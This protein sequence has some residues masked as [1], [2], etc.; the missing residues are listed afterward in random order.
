MAND[1]SPEPAKR[2]VFSVSGCITITVVILVI[3]AIA[4]PGLM[5]MR[6]SSGE[7]SAS[8]S[9]KALA[10]IEEDFRANDLDGNGADDYWT[11]NLAGLYC[12]E[13]RKTKS[14]STE[15]YA[16]RLIASS[17]LERDS[18]RV[19]GY[20]NE[21]VRYNADLLI[22][23]MTAKAGM[24]HQ[25][26]INDPAGVS[27]AQDTDGSG[28]KVHHLDAFGFMA[29]PLV[30]DST[31]TYCFIINQQ[32]TIYRRDFGEATKPP[33][34]GVRQTTFDGTVPCDF[35]SAAKLADWGKVE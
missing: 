7:R 6:I 25:A 18:P 16:I 31:G 28:F 34:P 20:Q 22:E 17:D 24:V 32:G 8:A 15:R 23:N 30:W 35:P 11:G 9:V 3:A 26:L 33:E 27:Y 13:N 5:R 29:M 21:S 12:L 4:I 1:P 14:P 10:L 19:I 2:R